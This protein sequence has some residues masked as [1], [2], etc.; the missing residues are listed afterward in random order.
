MDHRKLAGAELNLLRF[1][2][3]LPETFENLRVTSAGTAIYD[4]NGEELFRRIPLAR[5]RQEAAAFVDIATHAALGGPLLA[6]SQGAAWNEDALLEAAKAA[7]RKQRVK[8]YDT[9]RFVAYSFPK[10][11]VQFLADGQEVA[12][13]EVPTWIP[14]PP[15]LKRKKDEPPGNFERWSFLAETPRAVLTRRAKAAG[16]SLVQVREVGS[17]P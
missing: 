2:G 7:A 14:V 3:V 15:P 17:P 11:A 4:L 6:V 13:L 10:V 8:R 1:L 16:T 9:T 12:L 5:L